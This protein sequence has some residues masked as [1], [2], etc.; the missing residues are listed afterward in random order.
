ML[1]RPMEDRDTNACRT[2]VDENWGRVAEERASCQMMDY[3]KNIS[4]Y[5]PEF[6]V[7][8]DGAGNLLG[9]AGYQRSMRMHGVFDLIFLAV[10]K[11]YQGQG[12]GTA[13]TDH[14]LD[15]IRKLDGSAVFCVTQKPKYFNRFGFLTGSHLGNEWVEMCALLKLVDM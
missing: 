3:F 12:I 6:V 4:E 14:R 1:I 11:K 15:A 9:F 5:A 2:L 13:L 8:M 7:A 10:D